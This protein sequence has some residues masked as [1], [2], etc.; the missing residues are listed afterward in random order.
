MV[1][2]GM[3]YDCYTNIIANLRPWI[4]EKM[5]VQPTRLIVEGKTDAIASVYTSRSEGPASLPIGYAVVGSPIHFAM[6]LL[7]P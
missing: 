1:I 3:V 7:E 5:S 6:R 2:G 4:D